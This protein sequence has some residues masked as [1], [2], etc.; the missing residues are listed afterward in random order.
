[1]SANTHSLCRKRMELSVP[2]NYE[3]SSC[4]WASAHAAPSVSSSSFWR[5]P[6]CLHYSSLKSQ[7]RA[8]PPFLT[9]LVSLLSASVRAGST[10]KQDLCRSWQCPLCLLQ[11]R[12]FNGQH[13]ILEEAI[14]GDFALVK[15][16]KADRAGNVIFR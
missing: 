12:E 2:H 1:M 10:T 13:F 5:S 8:L 3:A 4:R 15:A 9:R 11:V 14:T 6:G 16:W 7:F